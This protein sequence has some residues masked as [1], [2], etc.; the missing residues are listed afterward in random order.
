MKEIESPVTR[1]KVYRFQVITSENIS[2]TE[3][4]IAENYAIAEE[5]VRA[6]NPN[7]TYK[8]LWEEKRYGKRKGAN[9]KVFQEW[10]IRLAKWSV[11]LGIF[12]FVVFKFKPSIGVYILGLAF[13]CMIV[14]G[15]LSLIK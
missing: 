12:G 14:S 5:Q 13:I 9:K 3:R 6:N 11:L 10:F 15:I 1:T 8:L 4:I 2:R 7:C